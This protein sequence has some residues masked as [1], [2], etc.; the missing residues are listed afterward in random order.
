MAIGGILFDKD[1]TL[2]DFHQTWMPVNREVALRVARGDA[3]LMQKLM[4]AGGYDPEADRFCAGTLLAAGNNLQIAQSWHQMAEHLWPDFDALLRL[5]DDGFTELSA[6]SATPVAD[7][8]ALVGRLKA[9]GLKLGIASADS[10]A[11]IHASLGG[12]GILEQFD[13]LSGYDS[14]YA[15][16]PQP[17]QVY[18]FMKSAGLESREIMMV[19]DNLHDLHMGLAA[20]AGCV[21]GVLTGTSTRNDLAPHADYVL[22]DVTG[23]EALLDGLATPRAV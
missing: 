17:D 5:V 16:K 2:L 6:A 9:R 21:V 18:G 7:L 19:G 15:A 11:G 12:F 4:I 8:A 1:G 23:I 22:E 20:R 3:A 10:L 14:G 13:F